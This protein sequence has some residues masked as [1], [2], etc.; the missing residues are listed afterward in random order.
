MM[1]PDAP[2]IRLLYRN[3]VRIGC[4][5]S[6]YFSRS[7]SCCLVNGDLYQIMSCRVTPVRCA[8]MSRTVTEAFSSSLLNCTLGTN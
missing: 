5:G 6:R 4:D 2:Y 7:N 3:V 1:Y 8:S